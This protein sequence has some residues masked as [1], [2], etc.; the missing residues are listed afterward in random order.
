[1]SPSITTGWLRRSLFAGSVLTVGAV[2]AI[3]ASTQAQAQ[4]YP[5]YAYNPY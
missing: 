4:Y 1:M 5:Y 3:G 2:A